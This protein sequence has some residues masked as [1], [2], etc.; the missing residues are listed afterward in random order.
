[1]IL[2]DSATLWMPRSSF[3][4]RTNSSFSRFVENFWML[5]EM[6]GCIVVINGPTPFVYKIVRFNLSASRLTL[7]NTFL[8]EKSHHNKLLKYN[9]QLF[10]LTNGQVLRWSWNWKFATMNNF[11]S[12]SN[13]NSHVLRWQDVSNF[14]QNVEILVCKSFL[15]LEKCNAVYNTEVTES[16]NHPKNHTNSMRW[17]MLETCICETLHVTLKPTELLND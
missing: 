15:W 14:A 5:N 8:A 4:F 13:G 10:C 2:H 17:R 9:F 6:D 11:C 12:V 16:Y 1:M 7:L 3:Y